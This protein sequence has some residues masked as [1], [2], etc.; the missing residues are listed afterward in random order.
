MGLV[1][2][3]LMVAVQINDSESP[4][5]QSAPSKVARVRM[6]QGPLSCP[7]EHYASRVGTELRLRKRTHI[8]IHL[9][10]QVIRPFTRVENILRH[11]TRLETVTAT[12]IEQNLLEEFSECASHDGQE[13]SRTY[14]QER[15]GNPAR[16]VQ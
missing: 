13:F 15:P 11:Q 9:V 6:E 7:K 16:Q 4:L 10:T 1:E 12:V 2:D 3:C 14:T 8:V 5:S